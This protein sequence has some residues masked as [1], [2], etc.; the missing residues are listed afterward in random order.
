MVVTRL[1]GGFLLLLFGLAPE[2]F[3]FASLAIKLLGVNCEV[4]K[5][6]NCDFEMPL[7][8]ARHRLVAA[9]SAAVCDSIPKTH[10]KQS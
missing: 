1:L 8:G 3:T 6:V 2:L 7:T 4:F 10:S 5:G 9:F